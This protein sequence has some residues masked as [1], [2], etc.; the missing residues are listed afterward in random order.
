[1][2]FPSRLDRRVRDVRF[3]FCF[4]LVE[5]AALVGG[6]SMHKMKHSSD[7]RSTYVSFHHPGRGRCCVRFS[8]H[9]CHSSQC[10]GVPHRLFSVRLDDGWATWGRLL[11]TIRFLSRLKVHAGDVAD[12]V[13]S[14]APGGLWKSG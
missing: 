6:W 8:E 11:H 13:C 9:R 10:P 12:V 1:M 14:A 3:M 2:A 7:G 5:T 4:R